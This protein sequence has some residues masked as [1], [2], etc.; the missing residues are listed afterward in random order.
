M[1]IRPSC[2]DGPLLETGEWWENPTFI[3]L[4]GRLKEH[5]LNSHRSVSLS[6]FLLDKEDFLPAAS[7]KHDIHVHYGLLFLL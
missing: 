7:Y 4:G 6:V 1:E 5:D 3:N 2:Q